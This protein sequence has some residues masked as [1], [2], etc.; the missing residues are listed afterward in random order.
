MELLM[1]IKIHSFALFA[2]LI[3]FSGGG[4]SCGREPDKETIRLYVDASQAYSQGRFSETANILQKDR[5]F[6]PALLLRAKAQYFA[7]DTAEAEKSCR[8]LLKKSPSSQ[9]GKLY[10]ARILR[11]KGDADGALKLTETL[12]TDNP[13]D[14]RALRLA[15]EISSELGRYSET[16]AFLDRAAELSAESAM[17]LLDRARLRWVAGRKPEALEDLSRA[18]AMLPWDTPLLRSINN[19][20]KTIKESL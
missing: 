16:A 20:E 14:I 8:K 9:E 6:P 3:I 12:L 4:I 1:L 13:Q 18:K 10:L 7:G 11:E 17:V 19:L 5:N 2:L 15:A